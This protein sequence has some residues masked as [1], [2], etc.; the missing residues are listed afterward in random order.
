MGQLSVSPS[1]MPR[2]RVDSISSSVGLLSTNGGTTKVKTRRSQLLQL[3]KMVVLTLIPAAILVVFIGIELDKTLKIDVGL[4]TLKKSIDES[5]TLGDFIHELQLELEAVTVHLA[6]LNIENKGPLN[7]EI[8]EIHD[9]FMDTDAAFDSILWWPLDDHDTVEFKSPERFHA[10]LTIN[11]NRFSIGNA[12]ATEAIL[13]YERI[14]LIFIEWFTNSLQDQ[15]HQGEL[16]KLL[17]AYKFIIRAKENTGIMAAYGE[18]YFIHG[19]LPKQDYIN[20]INNDVLAIDHLESCFRFSTDVEHFY[21]YLIKQFENN[22]T[23]IKKLTELVKNDARNHT[24][25]DDSSTWYN[26]MTEFLYILKQVED[27]LVH[28]ITEDIEK[29]DNIS[30]RQVRIDFNLGATSKPNRR[31]TGGSVRF[32]AV[33][34]V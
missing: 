19:W 16:W 7:H 26:V 17:L 33:V 4:K 22:Y 13:F 29:Q 31:L 1:L 34:I 21:D 23:Q 10:Y 3:L 28:Y 24:T 20:F 11:R 15:T 30:T 12:N 8:Y 2:D 9:Q 6:L 5:K 32:R 25:S 18:E 14:N 27:K